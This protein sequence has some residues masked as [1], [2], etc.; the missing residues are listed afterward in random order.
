MSTLTF[1]IKRYAYTPPDIVKSYRQSK[2]PWLVKQDSLLRPRTQ[3]LH[4]RSV[5]YAD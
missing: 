5:T 4:E 2:I 3:Q 1:Y